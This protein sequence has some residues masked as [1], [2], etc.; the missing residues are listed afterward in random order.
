MGKPVKGAIDLVLKS[1]VAPTVKKKKKNAT[2]AGEIPDLNGFIYVP[3]IN[4]YVAKE[5][6]LQGKNWSQT[7]HALHK[8]GLQMPSPYQFLKFI[9]Y[10]KTNTTVP[11]REQILDDILEKKDPWRGQWLD[12][13]YFEK[14]GEL[15]LAYDHRPD[16]KGRLRADSK[17]KLEDGLREDG[18]IDLASFTQQGLPTKKVSKKDIYYYAPVASTVA[19][20]GANS[21]WADLYCYGDPTGCGVRLGVRAARK[22]T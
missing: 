10:L 20:F 13:K 5:R 17:E 7:H 22:K 21:D 6:T 16:K 19:R 3:A 8:Q 12:S 18:Y 9:D 2:P 14:D 4:L 1:G 15:W 11:D